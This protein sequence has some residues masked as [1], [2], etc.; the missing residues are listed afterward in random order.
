[1]VVDGEDALV[2]VNKTTV[3]TGGSETT[4][5]SDRERLETLLLDG[6]DHGQA[7]EYITMQEVRVVNGHMA[8][9]VGLLLGLLFF[10]ILLL[11]VGYYYLFVP[12]KHKSPAGQMA[13]YVSPKFPVPVRP[14]IDTAVAVVAEAHPDSQPMKADSTAVPPVTDE[15]I[16]LYTVMVGPLITNNELE[17]AISQLR[18][19]GLTPQ[20]HQGRG[21]VAMIRLLQGIYPATDAREHLAQLKKVVKSAFVLPKGDKLA[22][23]AGSFHQHDRAKRMQEDLAQKR[24]DVSLVDSIIPMDGTML[25]VLQADEETAREVAVHLSGFGL[26]T[27]VLK[28][29]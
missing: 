26:Q 18:D 13:L 12:Q 16:S 28:K 7:L 2:S 1:M 29:K 11:G 23:Y 9:R 6:S 3:G 14:T 17:Q 10:S 24:V 20:Q 27:Q 21:Q 4:G 15:I 19:L 5:E 22:V 8:G 25:T